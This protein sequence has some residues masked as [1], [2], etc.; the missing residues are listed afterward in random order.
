MDFYRNVTLKH[1]I[2]CCYNCK[3]YFS[4]L[5]WC[6][7]CPSQNLTHAVSPLGY[8]KYFEKSTDN[9]R[10]DDCTDETFIYT[11]GIKNSGMPDPKEGTSPYYMYEKDGVED[12]ES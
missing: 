12:D 6:E 2:K 3:N 9:Y 11:I 5:S 4:E 10:L 7:F 8:C 1:N